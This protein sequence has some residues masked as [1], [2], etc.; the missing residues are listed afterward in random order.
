MC[1]AMAHRGPDGAGVW[2]GAGGQVILGHRRL[3]IIDLSP[4]AA[5]PFVSTDG[6]YA[7]V[8]N[9]EI[10]NYRELRG[11]LEREGV[12]FRTA[13][14]TEVLLALVAQRGPAALSKLRGMYAFALW[15]ERKRHLLLAR[16]PYG[17][18]PLYFAV[19]HGVL[20]FA[21][22]VKALLA[23]GSVD[24]R[25]DPL[26]L[27]GFLLWGY[28]P[29][30]LTFH[31]EV[32]S[33]PAGHCLE[34]RD[35][36]VGEPTPVAPWPVA[37]AAE[38]PSLSPEAALE[39]SVAAHL[40]ADVPVAVFLSAG[41]D[42]ALVTAMA[43]RRAS[44]RL[45]ALTLTFPEFQGTEHDEGPLARE[46]ARCLG[47][48]HS[49]YRIS[50]RE[51][52]DLWGEVLSAM[53]QPSIDGFNTYLISRAAHHGGFKVV[54]SG[55]GGDELFGS[56]PSFRGVPRLQRWARRVALLRPL[57]PV[58]ARAVAPRW[59]KLAG[60]AAFGGTLPG[61]YFLRRGL[62]L[63]WEVEALL[64]AN[65]F[66]EVVGAVDPLADLRA[67]VGERPADPWLA[68]HLLESRHYM[69]NQLL[70][71][72]DWASMAHSVE[73]RVPLVDVPLQ[74]SVAQASFEPARS[75]GKG[76]F[77]RSVAPELPA[78]VFQRRKTGFTTP[79]AAW[80]GL[81][82]RR[83]S[84]TSRALAL[85]VLEQ[86]GVALRVPRRRGVVA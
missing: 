3:A 69:R 55:L 18:K 13:S 2:D 60:L 27:A 48:E 84:V 70:R 36:S 7:L 10:Y 75:Q 62:F 71:D 67:T 78:A 1:D 56:Y 68:V 51:F 63:P 31:R 25:V 85:R 8:Y 72:A 26:G 81:G 45:Q 19:S 23:A 15:D 76:A 34:V 4:A 49:E 86:F 79:V 53:D 6:R 12:H 82:E 14:D 21:S 42:S 35:G 41:L 32:R 39:A 43:V 11:E 64:A 37:S 50:Q 83:G 58:A 57:W 74:R 47:V 29:E 38:E 59:P 5:Q 22:Q 46:V 65:G 80:L 66:Q 40:V 54:L 44:G 24:H 17:I 33:L 20:R 52:A 16:D 77:V 73:L 61:A 9:G 30:P 28:V